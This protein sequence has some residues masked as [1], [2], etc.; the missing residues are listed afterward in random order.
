MSHLIPRAPNAHAIHAVGEDLAAI[1]REKRRRRSLQTC[2]RPAVKPE[3]APYHQPSQA[4][5]P[6]FS[7]RLLNDPG[8]TDGARR[9]A[10][11]LLELAYRQNRTE[12]AYRGTVSYL[13]KG[14]GRSERAVQAYLALLR[15]RGYIRHEVVTSERARMCIGIVVTLLTPLFAKHHESEWPLHARPTRSGVNPSSENYRPDF[16]RRRG[17][18]RVSV[19][20]WTLR[21]MNGVFRALMK[22]TS[23]PQGSLA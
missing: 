23:A 21:C 19:E 22:S 4:Y 15:S 12:R 6:Q 5:V 10:I 7:A 16:K 8:L 17:G 3:Q 20:D 2:H 14:L 11:K 13:A 1:A 9:C 18:I